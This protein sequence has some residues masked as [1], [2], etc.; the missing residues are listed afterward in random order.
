MTATTEFAL[1]SC[2]RADDPSSAPSSSSFAEALSTNDEARART[3]G[4][5]P[6]ASGTSTARA[7]CDAVTTDGRRCPPRGPGAPTASQSGL[8]PTARGSASASARPQR[9][10][11]CRRGSGRNTMPVVGLERAASACVAGRSAPCLVV[12]LHLVG[13]GERGEPPRPFRPPRTFTTVYF[14]GVY[15]GRTSS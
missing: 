11:Q 1:H 10:T 7:A 2:R 15:G 3:G 5:L 4:R 6:G 8:C 13:V 9:R 12:V 14:G